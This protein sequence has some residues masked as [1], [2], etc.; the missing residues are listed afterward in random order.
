MILV[1]T[2]LG[3]IASS[4]FLALSGHPLN[5]PGWNVLSANWEHEVRDCNDDKDNED[6]ILNLSNALHAL[7]YSQTNNDMNKT[8]TM[9]T[10][11]KE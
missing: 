7:L 10:A 5:Y 11:V 9:A 4:F 6:C 1:G 3:T 8:L 2:T